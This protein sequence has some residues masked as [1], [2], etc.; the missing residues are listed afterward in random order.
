VI[1]VFIGQG[2][3]GFV[4]RHV[5]ECWSRGSADELIGYNAGF[6]ASILT[7]YEHRRLIGFDG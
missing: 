7:P 1:G 4:S 5:M 3:S 2:P 6:T